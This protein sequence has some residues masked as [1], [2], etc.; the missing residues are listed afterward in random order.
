MCGYGVSVCVRVCVH[1]Y[2]CDFAV[3]VCLSACRV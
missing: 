1:G 2:M 3:S